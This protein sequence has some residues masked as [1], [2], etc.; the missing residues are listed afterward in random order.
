MEISLSVHIVYYTVYNS[1][2]VSLPH[3]PADGCTRAYYN[4][5]VCTF[6][7]SDKAGRHHLMAQ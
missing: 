3:P 4:L 7:T 1:I 5:L 6:P 2:F